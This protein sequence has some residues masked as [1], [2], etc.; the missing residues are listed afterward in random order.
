MLDSHNTLVTT[1]KMVRNHIHE[2]P[3]ISLKLRLISQRD[4]DGVLKRISELHP[5]YL[6]LQYPILFPYGDDGCDNP[7]FQVVSCFALELAIWS[8]WS[9]MGRLEEFMLLIC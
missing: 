9:L 2:N 3:N 1:Y 4:R 7:N 6:A 8:S 5:S